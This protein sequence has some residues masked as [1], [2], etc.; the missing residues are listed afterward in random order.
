MKAFLPENSFFYLSIGSAVCYNRYGCN[1]EVCANL[2]D[3]GVDGNDFIGYRY[4][5]GHNR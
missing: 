3:S 2:I 1:Y 4:A 5:K